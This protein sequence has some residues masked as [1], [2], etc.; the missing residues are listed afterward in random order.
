MLIRR[1][2]LL[3][4]LVSTCVL[5][6]TASPAAAKDTIYWGNFGND[7]ISFANLDGTGGG[8]LPTGVATVDAPDGVAIDSPTGRLFWANY[9]G[10]SISFA[11][12]N[13]AGGNNLGTP[14]VAPDGP[15]GT[16]IDPVARRIYWAD[17][18]ADKISYA[19]LD[20]G[21]G[22]HL[23]TSGGEVD[24]PPA[25]LVD[26]A[27]G[28]VY[29]AN[30]GSTFPGIYYASLIGGGGGQVSTGTATTN[31]VDALAVDHATNT[32][33]WTNGSDN[34][35]PVSFA[36]LDGSGGGNLSTSGATADEANGLAIDRAAGR[37]YWAN[38]SNNTISYARLDNGG[39]GHQ[40]PTGGATLA[41]PLLPVILKAPVGTGAPTLSGGSVAGSALNC[42]NGAWA[43]DVTEASMFRAPQTVTH[44]WSRNGTPIA[45]ATGATYTPA[46]SGSY[47]CTAIG[48]NHAGNATQVSAART[49]LPA[50]P[51]TKIAKAKIKRKKHRA[52]FTFEVV[53]EKSGFRCALVKPRK[54]HHKKPKAHF[55]SCKSPKSYKKL[56]KG[57]Y[58]FEVRALNATG[59]DKTP[60]KKKFKI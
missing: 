17:E 37:I 48:T 41:K 58:T 24:V 49:V 31:F 23:S 7:T 46:L 53:G 28:R 19:R 38:Y 27:G 12:L 29:W 11:S 32:I 33:Y 4:S 43:A 21:G 13:G 57:R 16:S 55:K 47:R 14:G 54:K 6:A 51:G 56:K 25:V 3:L 20:G 36:R 30:A 5:L 10:D 34:A 15:N 39:G 35:H 60:A 22:Q 9:N 44:T 50:L 59:T 1:P 42:G 2:R 8:Q 18:N 40:L 26:R 52:K 45:G